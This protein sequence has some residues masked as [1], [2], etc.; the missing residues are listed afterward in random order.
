[1]AIEADGL[2]EADFLPSRGAKHFV[3]ECERVLFLEQAKARV[4][5]AKEEVDVLFVEVDLAEGFRGEAFSR[6]TEEKV[7]HSREPAKSENG[8]LVVRLVAM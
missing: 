8:D 3:P 2:V 1:M 5:W 7:R 6:G 4:A